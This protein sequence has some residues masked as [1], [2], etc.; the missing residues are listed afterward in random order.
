MIIKNK[1]SILTALVI[2]YLSLTGSDTFDK[3]HVFEIPFMD[4]IVHFIMYFGLMS[5]IILENRS[6]L[7]NRQKLLLI[8]LFPFFYGILLEICQ[9]LFTS[10]RSGSVSDALF[11]GLGIIVSLLVL[12]KIKHLLKSDQI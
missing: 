11:D 10:T 4:K 2:M 5:V 7:K 8:A 12:Y 9:A 6:L 3:V 1:F